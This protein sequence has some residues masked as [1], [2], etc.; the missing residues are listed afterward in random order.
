M[1]ISARRLSHLAQGRRLCT[2]L[3]LSSTTAYILSAPGR[4]GARQII[5]V[6]FTQKNL[7]SNRPP[8]RMMQKYLRAGPAEM[9]LGSWYLTGTKAFPAGHF[10]QPEMN[11]STMLSNKTSTAQSCAE[12]Q[13]LENAILKNRFFIFVSNDKYNNSLKSCTALLPDF[14]I[15]RGSS[16]YS[17]QANFRDEMIPS[18]G[19]RISI[20]RFSRTLDVDEDC[21]R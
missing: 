13:I 1:C 4:K 18:C 6:D 2:W 7:I 15:Q 19:F 20:H 21:C 10:G 14:S 16:W 9:S 17:E 8:L 12:D 5:F 11:N 3:W